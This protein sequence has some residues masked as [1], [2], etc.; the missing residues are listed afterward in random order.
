MNGIDISNWQNGLDLTKL[1]VDFAIMK[2]TEGLDFV[3]K[4]CDNWVNQAKKKGICWGFYHYATN[5]NP[6]KQADFFISHTKNYF[7]DGIPV[8]DIE[9]QSIDDWGKFSDKFTKR[10]FDVT[11]VWPL[12]YCSAGFLENFTECQ[13]P[14]NCGLWCAGYPYPAE[15]WTNRQFPY[16]IDPWDNVVI[17]Q[18]TDNLKLSGYSERLDGD[19]SYIDGKTWKKYAARQNQKQK[20]DEKALAKKTY[21]EIAFEVI[22]GEY[23]NGIDRKRM[24]EGMGYDYSKVQ[25]YVNELYSIAHKVIH[26][27]YGNGDD[28]INRLALAGYNPKAV[29]YI[30]NDILS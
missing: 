4:C 23:G 22:L 26:G 16:K 28:R 14:K 13:T 6:I 8:L 11:G 29:Q 12:I 30:V 24:L 3:D 19:I 21:K 5:D 2:A 17:W 1:N 20:Q 18:F 25:S 10:V 9:E 7:G 15:I 27:E